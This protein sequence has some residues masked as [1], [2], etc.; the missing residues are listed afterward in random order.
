MGGFEDVDG[1][2]GRF[3]DCSGIGYVQWQQD[4]GEFL[5]PRMGYPPMSVT[6][7]RPGSITTFTIKLTYF[8][9]V[10]DEIYLRDMAVDPRFQPVTWRTLPKDYADAAQKAYDLYQKMP[11]PSVRRNPPPR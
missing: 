6:K 5:D 8:D 10:G 9:G 2:V 1:A 11:A 3:W 7:F 4:H